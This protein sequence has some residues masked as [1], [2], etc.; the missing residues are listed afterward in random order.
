MP[1][2]KDPSG[3]RSVE[4]EAEVPGTPEQVW[5]AIATGPGIS[6]WFVPSEVD[7]R[8]GGSAVSHFGPGNSM[9]SVGTI[10]AWDPPRSFVVETV[11]GPGPVATEWTVEARAGGTCVVR[12]VHRWFASSDDWDDQFEG[13]T[14]GWAAVFRILRLYLAHF[15]G[16]SCASFQL[17]GVASEPKS[18]AWNALVR[19][20]G[21]SDAGVGTR[22]S[23]PPG[24][25]P[26]GGGVESAGP[27]E[28]P[29]LLV[30]LEHPTPGLAHF[31]AVPMG[32]RVFLIVRFFLYGE[33]AAAAA[34][35]AET[36]WQAWISDRFPFAAE[37]AP[38]DA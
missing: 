37:H 36:S 23:T 19:P 15:G 27:P 3:R 24:A 11:E 7:G 22:V 14:H 8:A 25:P 2:K 33:R 12:V 29:E 4:A 18:D 6:S 16:Q 13:H 35:P 21:L 17:M 5:N 10:K 20:L 32:G 38:S 34:G 31:A 1:V 9:D 28:W 26:L 30:R